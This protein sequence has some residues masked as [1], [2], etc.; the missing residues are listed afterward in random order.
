MYLHTPPFTNEH[1]GGKYIFSFSSQFITSIKS[2]KVFVKMA[3][4]GTKKKGNKNNKY[5]NLNLTPKKMKQKD[6]V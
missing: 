4:K 3:K 1:F 6:W 2:S 5:Q